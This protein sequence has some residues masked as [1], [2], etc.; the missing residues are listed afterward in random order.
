MGCETGWMARPEGFDYSLRG[1]D[2]VITHHHRRA[3]VLRGA[4][5]AQFLSRVEKEDAQLLMAR[6]TGNYARGNE[7]TARSHPRNR[8]S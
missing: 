5:A 6:A 1:N 7:K 4:A 2:V 8:G 3:A